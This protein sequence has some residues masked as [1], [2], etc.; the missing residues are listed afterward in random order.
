MLADMESRVKQKKASK[1][2][3]KLYWLMQLVGWLSLMFIEIFNVTF[4]IRGEFQW[5]YLYV[6]GIFPIIGIITTHFYKTF[7]IPFFTFDKGIGK[8]WGKAFLDIILISLTIILLSRLLTIAGPYSILKMNLTELL[9]S[10]GPQLLN[11][12]RYV[13]VWIIIYYLYHILQRNNEI[14]EEKLSAEI[15]TKTTELELL[16]T[17]L[18]P[19]FLFQSLS[20]IK[21]MVLKDK[22]KAR[23][24]ILKL[25]E[26]LRYSLNYDKTTLVKVQDELT[27]LYKYV[28]LEQIRLGDKLEVYFDLEE[29]VLDQ[30]IPTGSLLNLMEN[31]IRFG[32]ENRKKGGKIDLMGRLQRDLIEFLLEYDA[33]KP[34]DNYLNEGIDNLSLRLQKIYGTKA[35]LTFQSD[36]PQ[37][38]I[39]ILTLPKKQ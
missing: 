11:I 7:F 35:Q 1:E 24:S 12:S 31:A 39:C 15:K 3:R 5:N 30:E 29:A 9:A 20:S 33:D 17:Q 21:S 18:N 36:N 37:Q 25:S 26:L 38:I 6:F 22:E 27:E 4:F 19:S 10:L 32:I 16:K 13:M 8:V 34:F 14:L 2:K 23:D 28:D